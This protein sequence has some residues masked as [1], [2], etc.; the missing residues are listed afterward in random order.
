MSTHES[1]PSIIP[2]L[3][4]P[5]HEPE[6]V[7]A[8]GASAGGLEALEELFRAL[9]QRLGIAFVVIQHLLPDV[10]HHMLELVPRWTSLTVELAEQGKALVPDTIYLLP[11]DVELSVAEG[12]LV[13]VPRPP[14][15]TRPIDVFMRSCATEYGE[16]SIAVVLSGTG[17][18]GSQGVRDIHAA[19]GL[20]VVQREETAKFDGMPRSALETGVVDIAVSPREVPE[21]FAVTSSGASSRRRAPREQAPSRRAARLRSSRCCKRSTASTSL[22]TSP[23]PSPGES[24]DASNSS[25][26]LT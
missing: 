18:D 19:G 17:D 7:V 3:N 14:G 5:K 26:T 25:S 21:S 10:E 6:Y 8:I 2:A 16:R 12:C 1:P 23:A 15:H 24:S 9:T 4:D 11:P 13:L 22:S 20:V